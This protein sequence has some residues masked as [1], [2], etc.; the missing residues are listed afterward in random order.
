MKNLRHAVLPGLALTALVGLATAQTTGRPGGG[1]VD[2]APTGPVSPTGGGYSGPGDTV[3]GGGSGG[4]GTPPGVPGGPP[5][6]PPPGNPGGP[7][8]APGA[9]PLAPTF[10]MGRLPG[11][12]FDAPAPVT[13]TSRPSVTNP[14]SW[15]IW[16]HYNRWDYLNVRNN[17]A[18]TGSGGFYLGRGER[19]ATQ[20]VL[21]ASRSQMQDVVQPA[22]LEALLRGGRAELEIFCLHALAK[23]REVAPDERLGGFGDVV[24]RFLRSGN[25]DVAEKA[26]LALGIRGEDRFMPWL[27]AILGNTPMGREIV[28]RDQI[29]HR[30]RAFAAYGL[31]LLAERTESAEVVVAIHD[32]LTQALWIERPEVQAACLMAIGLNPLPLDQEYLDQSELFQGRTRVD[33]ILE[34]V[35]FFEDSKQSLVARSQAPNAIAR[36]VEDTTD[37]LRGR[38]AY[39]F[40]VASGV[41]SREPREVQNAAVIALG[42][43]GRA[44]PESIDVEI[45]SQLERVAYKSSVDRT[46]RFLAMIALGQVAGR[47]GEGEDPFLAVEPTRKVFVRYLG[48]SRGM[49]QA[50]TAL[51]LGILESNA[52]A[53]GELPDPTS[54]K[55]LRQVFKRTRSFE[56][57]G[58]IA[59][60]LGM[61]RDLE[62]E[63]LLRERMLDAGE[64]Q[65]RGYTALALGMIGAPTSIQPVRQILTGSTHLP[66]VVEYA[67]IGLALLGDQEIGSTLYSILSKAANPRVQASVAS[68]MGWI[69]DPRPLNQLCQQLVDTRKNDTGRAWTAVAVGRICDDDT[70]PWVGR[71]SVNVQY[72]VWLPT[73]IEPAFQSGLLDLP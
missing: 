20:P 10:P 71:L 67:S 65:I 13:P 44:G 43:I 35:S 5:P 1:P 2:G 40:L 72:D 66:F 29:G 61:L 7:T 6:P 59:I 45:R 49:S 53:R 36:L 48:R 31:G 27:V 58:A 9:N 47:G 12:E 70:W 28:G 69:R 57:G 46:T 8:Y 52:A 55:V 3:P 62:A 30:L 34:L 54:G 60:A 11:S 16:W 4:P 32:A 73:M 26:V 51:A 19:A 68:A 39:A 21:R 50:W 15:Q 56:V 64:E 63:E 17:R 41:H 22:I 24:P 42:A 37:S 38:A 18:V 14:E 23:L 25:Q 33:Q